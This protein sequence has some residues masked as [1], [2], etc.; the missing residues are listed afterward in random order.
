MAKIISDTVTITFSTL[1]RS[2]AGDAAQLVNAERL[3]T[4]DAAMQELFGEEA[5]VIV[6]V[7]SGE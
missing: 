5:G 6:E 2:D 3:E 1:V 4:L 7:S